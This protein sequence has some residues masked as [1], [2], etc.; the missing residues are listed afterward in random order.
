MS[1]NTRLKDKRRR[2]DRLPDLV[3]LRHL[4]RESQLER[5]VWFK[6]TRRK[7]QLHRRVS[8]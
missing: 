4:G 5:A 3:G 6:L 2:L 7:Q 1:R 8:G